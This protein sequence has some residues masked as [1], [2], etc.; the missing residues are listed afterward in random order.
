MR[1][2]F[3]FLLISLIISLNLLSQNEQWDDQFLP[4]N[5]PDGTIY[6][7]VEMNGDIYVGGQFTTAG[8]VTVNNIAKWDGTSWSALGT[9]TDGVVRTI[10]VRAN[11]LYVGGTFVNAG[12]NVVNNIA[13]WNGTNWSGYGTG[14][15]GTVNTIIKQG[16]YFLYIGGEFTDVNG[17]SANHVAQ[18]DGTNWSAMG[19]GLDNTANTLCLYNTDVLVGGIFANADGNTANNLAI[20]NGAN[21]S[22]FNGGTNAGV[23][24]LRYTN[25]AIIVGGDFSVVGATPANNIAMWNNASWV[26]ISN[27]VDSTVYSITGNTGELYITGTFS[28]ADGNPANKIAMWDGSSWNPLGDGL[29][30]DGYIVYEYNNDIFVGG[31]FTTAGLNQSNY[32]GRWASAPVIITQAVNIS[33]CNGDSTAFF[34]NVSSS[35]PLSYQWQLNG[36][37]ITGETNDTLI[38]NPVSIPDTGSYTCVIDNDFGTTTSNIATLTVLEA[39]LFTGH[40]ADTTLCEGQSITF[41][42]AVTGNSPLFQWQ[43]NGSNIIGSNSSTYNIGFVLPAN[44]GTYRC[45]AANSCGSDTSNSAML[46]VNPNPVVSFTGL[47]TIYCQG[48]ISDTLYGTPVAGIFSGNGITNSIFTPYSLTGYQTITYTYTDANFCVSSMSQQTYVHPPAVTLSIS[49][50]ESP[51]CYNDNSDTLTG[52]PFGGYFSGEGM[53]DSIFHPSYTTSGLF[54]ISYSF[55][56]TNNCVCSINQAVIVHASFPA[57]FIGIENGYCPDAVADTFIITPPGGTISGIISD[58]IFDPNIAGI[59]IHEIYYSFTD[60]NSCLSIDTFTVHVFDYTALNLGN[61]TSICYG[62]S[63]SVDT[64]FTTYLWS[65]SDTVN[66]IIPEITGSYS[67]TVSDINGCENNANINVTI[68]TTPAIDLGNDLNITTSQVVIIGASGVYDNYL[69]NTGSTGNIIFVDGNQLGE[70]SY[71]YWL[72]VSQANGCYASDTITVNVANSIFVKDVDLENSVSIYPNPVSSKLF[73]ETGN[74]INSPDVLIIDMLGKVVYKSKI[75][76]NITEIDVSNIPN[77]SYIILLKGNDSSSKKILNIL[78]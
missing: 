14:T 55:I 69:W 33:I 28:N 52:L 1:M 43:F 72:S 42:I 70:G 76:K 44:N 35:S 40:P 10:A 36:S 11:N 22:E 16:D 61:D 73:I 32:F 17:V 8:G 37:D 25:S 67:I 15:N 48:D 59:G 21:W 54:D 68:M 4:A 19:T 29:N 64:I 5:A 53:L 78:H 27:G 13:M 31:Q 34:I 24:S 9:G 77:G 3:T 26:A 18:W 60:I 45:Y 12:G 30:N 63:I 66:I 38:I 49:G 41:N 62:Q 74:N 65:T 2:K 46:T 20:W 75:M 58:T 6:T 57:D 51:Y 50:L 39:P 56:D 7:I 71:S 23:Y 47:D